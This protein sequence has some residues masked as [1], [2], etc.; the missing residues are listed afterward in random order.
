MLFQQV[1]HEV[2]HFDLFEEMA[3]GYPLKKEDL[4]L[5]GPLLFVRFYP[6]IF[7]K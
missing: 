4:I 7:F 5:G 2:I 6:N 1:N 3:I